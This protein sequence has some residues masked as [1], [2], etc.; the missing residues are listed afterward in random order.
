MGGPVDPGELGFQ[1]GWDPNDAD[2][3]QGKGTGLFGDFEQTGCD[4]SAWQLQL[5]LCSGT[6][7]WT[8]DGFV[9]SMSGTYAVEGELLQDVS[10]KISGKTTLTV[11]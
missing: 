4:P 11:T 5:P 2:H 9:T 1:I 3:V 8:F 6:A 7:T 10:V